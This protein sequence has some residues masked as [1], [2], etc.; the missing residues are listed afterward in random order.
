MQQHFP[1]VLA[2]GV[3]AEGDEVVVVRIRDHALAIRTGNRIK[4]LD[5][6]T[7]ALSDFGV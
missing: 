1:L 4:R 7:Y 2:V 3:M 5:D 6:A